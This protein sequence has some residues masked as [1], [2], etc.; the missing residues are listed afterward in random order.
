MD[1]IEKAVAKLNK[2]I[3]EID[4]SD[5]ASQALFGKLV[6]IRDLLED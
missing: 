1:C 2:V 5:E 4:V 3:N 6:E